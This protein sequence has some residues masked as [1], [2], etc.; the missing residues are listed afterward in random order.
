[1]RGK[2]Y[3][4]FKKE[5]LKDREVKLIYEK[6]GP[7]KILQKER[8]ILFC[9]LFG[10]RATKNAISGSDV[11]L[12]IYF[13][14]NR[15]K[16]F[17]EKRLGLIAEISRVLKKETDIVV[18]NTAPPFLRYVILKE[19]K[20]IFERD[21]GKRID[22]ELKSLNEYFDFKPILEKYHQRLLIP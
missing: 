6:L 10:S 19:G 18:L 14:K 21:K 2:T 5:L 12:A 9:Y 3:K 8:G 7:Q 20:L 1:M 11:D 13:D 16:D 17:F 4:Q 15:V 22:F